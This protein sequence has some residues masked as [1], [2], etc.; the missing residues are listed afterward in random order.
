MQFHDQ[1]E[2]LKYLS[3]HWSGI[4]LIEKKEKYFYFSLF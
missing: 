3:K 2:L 1:L 4:E